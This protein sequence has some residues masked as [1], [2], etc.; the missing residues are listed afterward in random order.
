VPD[1]PNAERFPLLD[2]EQLARWSRF[3][4]PDR[5]FFPTHVGLFIDE[6]R[7]GYARL[8]LDSRP[9]VFQ[10]DGVVH[11]GALSTL[12][13]TAAVPAIGTAYEQQPEMLTV[14]LT[15]NFLGVV[16][17]E[18]AVAEAWVEQAGR[19]MAFVRA[20]VRGASKQGLAATA[21]LVFKVKT[22]P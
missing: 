22:K 19:T 16:A 9:E 11:G 14:S 8:R 10:A 7:S 1:W 18:D 20:E 3:L 17:G 6:L 15:M 13:D 2:D 4:R 21:S 5:L 12:V